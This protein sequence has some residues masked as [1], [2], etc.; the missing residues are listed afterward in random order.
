MSHVIGQ[1]TIASNH[2]RTSEYRASQYETPQVFNSETLEFNAPKPKIKNLLDVDKD[3]IK[4]GVKVALPDLRKQFE[5]GTLDGKDIKKLMDDFTDED[6]MKRLNN[7]FDN[8]LNKNENFDWLR[9]LL[10]PTENIA[11]NKTA[12]KNLAKSLM[13]SKSDDFTKGITDDVVDAAKDNV[14]LLLKNSDN[15]PAGTLK[16]KIAK[17]TAVGTTTVISIAVVM[18][19]GGTDTL[20]KWT[21]MTTGLDCPEKA[22][23]QGF[24]ETSSE[25][26]AAVKS[27][28]EGTIESLLKLGYGALAI[29]GFIGLVAVTR[30][31]P[32]R[33]AKEEREEDSEDEE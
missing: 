16:G 15:V 1:G 18:G 3:K 21:N 13:G 29:V 31:I 2:Y 24:E 32:K 17:Y 10:D 5:A 11:N 6:I 28:Q 9:V 12:R 20:E 4:N 26:T 27:C 19:L 14:D 23:D 30:A 7:I 33:K 22:A 25:Y 8:P